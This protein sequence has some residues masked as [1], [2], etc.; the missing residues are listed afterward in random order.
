MSQI[1]N[2]SACC[3]T[4]LVFHV[5]GSTSSFW[6]NEGGSDQETYVCLETDKYRGCAKVLDINDPNVIGA[7]GDT[8]TLLA[9]TGSN[10]MTCEECQ[11][12][13]ACEPCCLTCKEYEIENGSS[14]I[15]QIFWTDCNG[16]LRT[17]DLA[18]GLTIYVCACEGSVGVSSGDTGNIIIKT[19]GD[20]CTKNCD[21]ECES[22]PC[23]CYQFSGTVGIGG[24]VISYKDC[25]NGPLSEN[26]L[27][28][29]TLENEGTKFTFC[30]CADSDTYDDPSG[31][32][33][34]SGNVE[35]WNSNPIL[36]PCEPTPTPSI[37]I[38][39]SLTPTPSIS[40]TPS[41]TP[42]PSISINPTPT[43]SSS[44][45]SCVNTE[46]LFFTQGISPT[47]S[48][49]MTPTPTPSIQRNLNINKLSTY[50]INGGEFIC[51]NVAR[52]IS[53]ETSEVFFINLP[54]IYEGNIIPIGTILNVQIDNITYCLIYANEVVGSSSHTI[55]IINSIH[56][57]CNNCL[58]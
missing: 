3:E 12:V 48:P 11:E 33:L 46:V 18:M 10:F 44:I 43:P 9:I 56:N 20:E 27:I 23:D 15:A 55:T 47:P 17:E 57:N 38:T 58:N 42:T 39:P 45:G 26:D 52:L 31:K 1:V 8:H 37:S 51:S 6:S 19:T 13:C 36:C 30:A 21:G 54:L 29:L 41:L 28:T 5:S 7:S 16:Y 24:A 4:N 25:F 34:I 49:T 50:L 40:I 53:C 14:G 2:L 35:S 22:P 32:F